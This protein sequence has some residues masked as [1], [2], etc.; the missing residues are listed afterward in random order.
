MSKFD[1]SG[2]VQAGYFRGR[3]G[4]PF[5][6]AGCR[7]MLAALA[8]S[9]AVAGPSRAAVTS[10]DATIE[11]EVVEFNGDQQVSSDFAREDLDQ[12]TPN[13]PLVA[14]AE[15]SRTGEDELPVA[16][17][18]VTTTF[19]D[20][21]RRN[22]PD[23]DELGLDLA[24]FSRSPVISYSGH[25]SIT[26]TRQ[27]VF[28]AEEMAEPAGTPL[29]IRS[30]FFL[31]GLLMLW[32]EEGQTD[33]SGTRT[34]IHLNVVQSGGELPADEELLTVSLLLEGH[35][36]GTLTVT[37]GGALE[38]GNV[39]VLD[40]SGTVGGFGS[41]H[42]VVLPNLSIPYTYEALVDEPFQLEAHIEGTTRCRPGTGASA[43]LGVPLLELVALVNS[44]DTGQGDLLGGLLDGIITE[45]PTASKPLNAPAGETIIV[46][47]SARGLLPL[48]GLCGALGVEVLGIALLCGAAVSLTR[49]YR[50]LR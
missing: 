3:G 39:V 2:D 41:L 13:L 36:D 33:L 24:V 28:T 40:M 32:G 31:D 27:V 37:P 7:A 11:S 18:G 29:T 45:N 23:P 19:S 34:E 10:F 43:V 47:R 5:R 44:V 14:V 22:T 50:R 38:I 26:E 21:R 12:T 48:S 1:R 8:W 49:S 17:G 16:A 25:S 15:L 9:V 42:V 30:R 4:H 46:G 6:V 20:P 35:A